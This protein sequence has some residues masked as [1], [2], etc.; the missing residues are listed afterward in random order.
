MTAEL[1]KLQDAY[2]LKI[3]EL[4]NYQGELEKMKSLAGQTDHDD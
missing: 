1:N 4:E 2:S 3:G